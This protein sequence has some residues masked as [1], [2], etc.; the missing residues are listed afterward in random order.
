MV[1]TARHVANR[2][3]VCTV[4]TVVTVSPAGVAVSP[5]TMDTTVTEVNFSFF[6]LNVRCYRVQLCV[7]PC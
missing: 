2:V 1:S 3:S 6:L 5:V 4:L 7:H